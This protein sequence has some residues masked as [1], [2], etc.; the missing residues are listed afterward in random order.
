MK[1]ELIQPSLLEGILYARPIMKSSVAVFSIAASFFLGVCADVRAQETSPAPTISSSAPSIAPNADPATATR[2]WLDTVP[3]EK[4]AKSDAYFEGGYWLILWNFLLAAAIS[5]FLLASRISARLRDFA[6]RTTRFK[7]LQVVLYAIPFILL[8]TLLAFPLTAYEHFFREHA[9]GLA[10]QNFGQWFRE[11]LI[12]LVVQLI[13]TS[14]LLVGLYS[15]FRRTP[16]TWWIWGTIVSVI[17]TMLGIMLSPVYIEPLFNTYKPLNDLA[18]SEPILAMARANEIPVT[19]VF[20][21]D[22]SRQS[23]RV[24]ANVAGFL[25]TTRIALNDNLLKQCTLPEIREVMAHEM[26]HYILNHSAK[27]VMYFGLFFLIGFAVAKACFDTAARLHERWG[28]RVS[29]APS[30]PLP[31]DG[32]TPP[33]ETA[34]VIAQ[35]SAVYGIADPAGLPLLSLIFAAVFFLLTPLMNTVV[36]VTEREAD[37]FSINTSREPDGMAKVALKLG[38]Y[39]KLDPTPLEEFI[40]FDHPSGRARIRM[41]MDWKAAHLPCAG[42]DGDR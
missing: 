1:H 42:T 34:K 24:S 18:I 32:M 28:L 27:L 36:R 13:V 41:A 39:R 16:Q 23:N 9:Y 3:A 15:V 14:L 8:T 17:F 7:A 10:T 11:Q 35:P 40:F 2:A 29:P 12:A 6:E 4:R 30:D 38:T 21:V 37:A 22:A 5:I 20:E 25:G 31:D 33:G 19:Q 26:G